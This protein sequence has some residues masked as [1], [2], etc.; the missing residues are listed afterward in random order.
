M[1]RCGWIRRARTARVERRRHAGRLG[2][3]PPRRYG[4]A[5]PL[6]INSTTG[7]AGLTLGGGFGWLSR[8]PGPH[9][10]QPALGRGG[11]GGGRDRAR[12]RDARTPT[13]SGR[14]RGGGGNF[15]IV[16]SFEFQLHPV[17]PEVL[18]GL[19]VHP[20]GEA[21]RVL[22]LLPR[23]HA[24][25]ARGVRLLVRAAPGAAAAVPARRSGTASRSSRWRCATRATLA[26]GERVA[27]PLREFGKPLADVVGAACR[28]PR[29]QTALDPLLTPGRPQLLEV[30][31]LPATLSDGL[32]DVLL[33]HAAAH[34]RSA[35]RD[36][37]RA[38]GRR[39]HPRAGRRHGVRPSRRAVR[40]ERARPLGRTRPRTRRASLGARPVPG[41]GAVRDRGR[42]RELPD[43]GGRRSGA[44]GLRRRTTSGW[45]S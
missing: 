44:R 23:L 4:L 5:T 12:Q 16:T 6:G 18:S 7:I 34:S 20:L 8:K 10:R 32:I 36:R 39:G 26:E 37:L 28:T 29:W 43:R 31:R 11:D 38:A 22:A 3:Q 21:Q 45:S 9:H 40:D 17:G 42:V 13:C 14:I 35:D 41:G 2:P 25:R 19:V 24:E 1:R 27:A 33:E 15:G 30:A